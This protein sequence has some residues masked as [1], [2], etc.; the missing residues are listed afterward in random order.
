MMGEFDLICEY[1]LWVNFECVFVNSMYTNSS[2]IEHI[3]E[4]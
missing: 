4:Y 2:I 3:I 1:E